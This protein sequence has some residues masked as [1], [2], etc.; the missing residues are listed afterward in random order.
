MNSIPTVLPDEMNLIGEGSHSLLRKRAEWSIIETHRMRPSATV[1]RGQNS[2]A[3]SQK[4]WEVWDRECG[5]GFVM[6]MEKVNG[7][8]PFQKDIQKALIISHI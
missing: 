3:I 2:S 8:H 1:T 7:Q 6:N 5:S 4:T